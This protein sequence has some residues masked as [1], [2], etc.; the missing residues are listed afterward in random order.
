MWNTSRMKSKANAGFV[1]VRVEGHGAGAVA[2]MATATGLSQSGIVTECVEFV[3]VHADT[4]MTLGEVRSRWDHARECWATA[5]VEAA[6]AAKAKDDY[7]KAM[8]DRP[9]LALM[10]AKTTKGGKAK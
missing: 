5:Q 1:Q 4:T 2:E 3:L 7:R 6:A 10:G 8:A 9:L